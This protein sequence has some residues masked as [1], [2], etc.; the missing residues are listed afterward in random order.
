[1]VM[2]VPDREDNNVALLGAFEA[3]PDDVDLYTTRADDYFRDRWMQDNW[4]VGSQTVP[5][6]DGAVKEMIT[7]L[8]LERDYGG[9][10]LDAFVPEEWMGPNRGFL[11]PGGAESSHNYG[12]N[13]E[14]APPTADFP[15]GRMLYG[16]GDTTLTGRRNPDTMN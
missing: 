14:V 15:F 5:G 3:L 8:Q 6:T 4:E 13:L 1:F 2:N 12:G 10:G 9:Q 11:Y 7:A 16:G